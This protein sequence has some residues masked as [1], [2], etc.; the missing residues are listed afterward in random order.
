MATARLNE[1]EIY[2]VKVGQGLPCLVMHGGLGMDH[3]YLHPWL[4]PLED[5]LQLIYYDHRGNGRS[6]RPPAETLNH[7]QFSKDADALRYRLGYS[8]VAVIGHSYGGFI[9][10]EYALRYPKKISHLILLNTAP[11][12]N[13]GAEIRANLNRKNPSPEILNAFRSST[14]SEASEL[15]RLFHTVLPLYFHRFN[16][17]LAHRLFADVIWSTSAAARNQHLLPS[18]N[19]IADLKEIEIPTLILVGRDDFVCPPS[20]AD[21]LH[22]HISGSELVIFEQSGHFPYVEEPEAF[23]LSV[24][25]WLKRVS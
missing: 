5:Q 24:R 13:Y 17:K 2:Y 1:T 23:F 21:L 16:P 15:E 10:L 6:D 12:Y 11:A 9:A 4:D 14:P 3:T 25:S 18:Y 20:Q 7:E 22:Q 19:V 8:R